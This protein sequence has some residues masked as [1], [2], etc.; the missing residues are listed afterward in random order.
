MKKSG[1]ILSVVGALVVLAGCNPRQAQKGIHLAPTKIHPIDENILPAEGKPITIF[2]HGGARPLSSLI[3]LPGLNSECPR[4]MRLSKKL[5]PECGA[6]KS[7]FVLSAVDPEMFPRDSFY[8]F[9]WSGFLSFTHRERAGQELY[10]VLCQLRADKRYQNSKITIITYSHGGNVALNAGVTACAKGDSR[11]LA[12]LLVMMACPVVIPTQDF[13]A[14][15]TFKQVIA[16]YSKS[17]SFQVFDPQGLYRELI[18]I[19]CPFIFSKRRFEQ[20]EGNSRLIQA[21]V[22]IN[23]RSQTGHLG[24]MTKRVL[25]AL[26][27][28]IKLLIDDEKRKT[29]PRYKNASYCVS[30]NTKDNQVTGCKALNCWFKDKKVRA[31][32]SH[33]KT[34]CK[35]CTQILE[36][37]AKPRR[38]NIKE[39]E[40]ALNDLA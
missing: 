3:P 26:P 10:D 35:S 7:A 16:L 17:D 15:P 8:N 21:E 36:S 23:N 14:S 18:G 11:P 13:V 31:L 40:D 30:I 4:G 32:K 25:R 12:D 39:K 28:I 19:P 6:R 22:K 24:F 33:A 38:H 20:V 9:G 2:V 37:Y 34:G 29:L 5:G 27:K 1:I